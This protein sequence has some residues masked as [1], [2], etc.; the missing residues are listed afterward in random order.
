MVAVDASEEDVRAALVDGVDIAAVNGP[1]VGRAVRRRG[2]RARGRGAASRRRKRLTCQPRVPLAPDGPDAGRVPRGRRGADLQPPRGPGRRGG[3]RDRPGVLG[4]H[5]RDAVRF[6]DAVA[7]LAAARR[8][9]V[10]RGRPGRRADRPGRRPGATVR[11]GAAPRPRRPRRRRRRGRP[12]CT[13]PASASTGPRGSPAPAPGVVDLPTYA[14]QHRRYWPEA[15]ARTDRRTTA[16]WAVVEGGDL[17]ELAAD[18]QVDAA[19]LERSC[20]RCRPCAPAG[21]GSPW[22]TAG[23]TASSGVP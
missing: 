21:S 10:R 6:A 16:F 22:W 8:D 18:L 7:D 12:P 20:P 13:S 5:V 14:F 15:A 2:R 9:D 17:A 1:R 4:R 11:P 23:A 3:R 19:A